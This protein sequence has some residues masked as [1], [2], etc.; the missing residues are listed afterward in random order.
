MSIFQF[1]GPLSLES[2]LYKGRATDLEKLIR[3]CQGEIQHYGI[4]YGA[5]Q[6]GK[7]SLLLRLDQYLA[8][9][10]A[11]CWVDFE[12][13]SDGSPARA[14]TVLAQKIAETLKMQPPSLDIHDA[15]S[16]ADNLC[17]MLSMSSV[18]KLV[19]MIEEMGALQK[20][21][22]FAIANGLRAIFND[23]VR[24]SRRILSKFM[25]IIAGNIEVYELASTEV[26]PIGNICQKHYLD[27]LEQENA[28]A[29]IEEGMS[30]LGVEEGQAKTI[31]MHIY[32]LT[33][34]Y[35]YLTQRLGNAI[36]MEFEEYTSL[37]HDTLERGISKFL[38]GDNALIKH[39]RRSLND[40]DLEVPSRALILGNVPF[41]RRDEGMA[42]LEL[43]GLARND[44][45]TWR[46]RNQLFQRI[47]E[48]WL[49]EQDQQQEPLGMG[50]VRIFDSHAVP[51]GA[52]I[53][54][55]GNRVVT[56]G[57]VVASALDITI[58]ERPEKEIAFDFPLLA[59][60]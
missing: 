29:L 1:H 22:R 15:M 2:P 37:D 25:V 51:V 31:A 17:Q 44:D 12:Y 35:P 26:S 53:L 8:S 32:E 18:P 30:T 42:R 54:V 49:H 13:L 23:R 45:N 56:C 48:H 43:I 27:D 57:H 39:I 4:L 50:L 21:T 3:W 55:H 16:F 40:Q 10:A 52:G 9:S 46:V 38:L 24:P 33:H 19:L 36:E 34:G 11:V 14:F 20:N 6:C 7:T 58:D 28:V 59:P 41:D 47:L 60:V 5:R